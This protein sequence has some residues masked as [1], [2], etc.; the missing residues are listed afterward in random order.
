[1]RLLKTLDR[2]R[3]LGVVIALAM[4]AMA[5]PAWGE[6]IIIVRH[7][8]RD[9][10]LPDQP[11][12]PAGENRSRWIGRLLGF[13]RID[14]IF[15]A[16]GKDDYNNI[17]ILPRQTGEEKFTLIRLNFTPPPSTRPADLLP[18]PND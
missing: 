15:Y 1:M 18:A 11:L 2:G 12:L 6:T 17:Y 9:R 5:G 16:R 14:H 8:D 10:N 4:A 3:F 13:Q 7:A